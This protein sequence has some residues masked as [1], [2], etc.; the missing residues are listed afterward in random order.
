MVTNKDY[1]SILLHDDQKRILLQKRD[2]TPDFAG[3]RT[4]GGKVDLG[5][6]FYESVVRETSEELAYDL[7]LLHP[8]HHMSYSNQK[9]SGNWHFFMHYIPESDKSKLQLLEGCDWGWFSVENAKKFTEIKKWGSLIPRLEGYM[10]EGKFLEERL[11]PLYH[12]WSKIL[13]DSQK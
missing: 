1:V 5:E 2:D 6:I 12:S 13:Q 7:N 9:S 8:V 10:E 11:L 4:F 3:W